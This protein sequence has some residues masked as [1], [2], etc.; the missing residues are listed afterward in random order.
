VLRWIGPAD[1][2][3]PIATGGYAFPGV[4][5]AEPILQQ[6]FLGRLGVADGLRQVQ[7]AANRAVQE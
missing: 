5:A 1:G 6:V 2:A 4:T 3:R 7:T